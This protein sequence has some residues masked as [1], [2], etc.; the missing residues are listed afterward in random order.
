ML[1]EF[2]IK[3]LIETTEN[4]DIYNIM[5]KRMFYCKNLENSSDPLGPPDICYLV[6][7]IQSKGFFG[8]K[9]KKITKTGSYHYVYGLDTSNVAF[10]S[11]YIS[12]YI[13]K[14]HSHN[15]NYKI[16]QSIFCVFDY[17]LE[18]DLRIL[19][20]FP[21]GIRKIF[22]ID[23]TQAIEANAEGLRTVFLS[24]ILRSWSFNQY[25][26]PNNSLFL[27]EINSSE[28]FDFLFDSIRI[29]IT[30]KSEK[31]EIS[32]SN[33]INNNNVINNSNNSIGNNNTQVNNIQ[34]KYINF[35]SKMELL[36]KYFMKFLMKTRRFN[37]TIMYFSKLT[38]FDFSYAKYAIEPLKFLNLYEDALA[39]LA[40]ML[41]NQQNIT[42][43]SLEID[44]LI[45]LKKYEDAL[46]IA[47]FVTSLNP[48]CSENWLSLADLYL[49]LKKY[50]NCLRALNNVYFLREFSTS[51]LNKIK[52]SEGIMINEIPIQ[53]MRNGNDNNLKNSFNLKM[54]DILIPQKNCIDIYFNSSQFYISENSDFLQNTTMKI[55]N[56]PYY[57]FDNLQ[58]KEYDILLELIK[59]IN[60]DSFIDLKRKNFC[61]T[62]NLTGEK[63]SYSEN[64]ISL[65]N[66][67]KISMNP[68]LEMVID[69]LI[70]DLKIFSIVVSEDDSYLSQLKN[71]DDLSIS[72]VKFCI[73]F[74]VLS[75]RLKY[76]NT[77]MTFYTKS[78][79][80][81]FSKYVFM[82]KI[83]I[84][85]KEK[86][87]KVA[88]QLLGSLLSNISNE[89][90]KLINKTPL[91]IDKIVLK[92]LY[93]FQANEIIQWVN[94]YG[95]NIVDFIKKVI[96]KY[97]YW[98]EAG[99][100]IHLIK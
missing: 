73:A 45:K 28:T 69:N 37:F 90:F 39:Y 48:G 72:E 67:L 85:I 41:I 18:K 76:R 52:S 62:N 19:I 34:T 81:S 43:L 38:N 6:K 10:I 35:N 86:N 24:S 82:R 29:L 84:S 36:L 13:Q 63:N 71:K 74:G 16:S 57:L 83:N 1:Q 98:I 33:M 77:A 99:H 17:F 70:D 3:D 40:N 94:E 11:A 87:Y 92:V 95:K 30:E 15:S 80:F 89:Q 58:K 61:E 100:E 88:I 31:I 14:V 79:Q 26:I 12:K 44:I 23:D 4:E 2:Y 25:P 66:E 50:D 8:L 68:Y 32:N 51:D 59:E 42:L 55:L 47:K 53:K 20:K 5:N 9:T 21:G 27:E 78:L 54:S 46:N 7:E 49:K 96:N 22:Y 93:E 64:Q 97:K 60:F 91:W 65:S 56:C 75:E